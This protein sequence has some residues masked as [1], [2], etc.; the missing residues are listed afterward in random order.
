[1]R[2]RLARAA[3]ENLYAEAKQAGPTDVEIATATARHFVELDRPEAFRVVHAL[4]KLPE[5]PDTATTARARALA[6]RLAE[7]V[8]H[9]KDEAD[10]RAR[11]EALPDRGNLELVVESL[12]PVAADGR[13]VD[14]AHPTPEPDTYV[15]PFA[16]A[17]ARLREPGQKSGVVPTEFGFH[18]MMLLERTAPKTV[19]LEERRRLLHDEIV[20]ERAKRLKT[21]L[22]ARLAAATPIS[23][24]RSAESV[25]ATVGATHEAP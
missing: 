25:L 14:A 9:A 15:V 4:V 8:A 6:D 1:V 5:K 17:A 19:P 21:E 12:K 16:A 20:T 24:E 2:A 18:V 11:A 3:L 22:I 23:I 13:V 10:F 7:Q